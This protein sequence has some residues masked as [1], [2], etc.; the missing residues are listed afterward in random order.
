MAE[1]HSQSVSLEKR[2]LLLTY[3]NMPLPLSSDLRWRIVML[4]YYRDLTMSEIADLPVLI[5][6][7]NGPSDN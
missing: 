3:L 4:Y 2:Q 6:Y 5:K 7:E 1:S